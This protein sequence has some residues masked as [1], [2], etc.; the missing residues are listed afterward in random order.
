MTRLNMAQ[1]ISKDANLQEWLDE[2]IIDI[3]SKQASDLN[4]RGAKA[5]LKYLKDI[6]DDD[7][8]ETIYRRI[9]DGE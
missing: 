5:Q 7:N 6:G 8:I 2:L 3:F 4:N 9:I 1:K